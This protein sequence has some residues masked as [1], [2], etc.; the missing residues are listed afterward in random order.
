MAAQVWLSLLAAAVVATLKANADLYPDTA[1]G[2]AKKIEVGLIDPIESQD[3]TAADCDY[4]AVSIPLHG[5]DT[6]NGPTGFAQFRVTIRISIVTAANPQTVAE[7]KCQNMLSQ[8]AY[9]LTGQL[10]STPFGLSGTKVRSSELEIGQ[11]MFEGR[12]KD[13][14][15]FMIQ[16]S[17]ESKVLIDVDGH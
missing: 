13:G 14:S 2:L 8:V 3:I 16:G 9:V 10:G 7:L 17:N 5:P 12:K 11:G 15:L 6:K 4:I 1:S